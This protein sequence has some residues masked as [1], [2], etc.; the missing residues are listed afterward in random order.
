VYRSGFSVEVRVTLEVG[1]K[2]TSIGIESE[3]SDYQRSRQ[4]MRFS[5]AISV[6]FGVNLEAKQE[7]DS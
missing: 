7:I 6:T 4:Q 2:A 1:S 5:K 3:P